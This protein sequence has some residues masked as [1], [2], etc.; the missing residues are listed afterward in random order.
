MRT[1]R[2]LV[3]ATV[4]WQQQAEVVTRRNFLRTAYNGMTCAHK[5][6]KFSSLRYRWSYHE[7]HEDCGGWQDAMQL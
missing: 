6:L 5:I 2:W 4:G 1:T 7:S 3:K